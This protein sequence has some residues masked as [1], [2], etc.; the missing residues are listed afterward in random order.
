LTPMV[1]LE[2]LK[3]KPALSNAIELIKKF[4][5]LGMIFVEFKK[6]L[7][8]M[9]D[10]TVLLTHH[11]I[12]FLNDTSFLKKFQTKMVGKPTKEEFADFESKLLKLWKKTELCPLYSPK[13]YKT[14]MN[15]DVSY[16][17]LK[18]IYSSTN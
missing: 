16:K 14:M 7:T 3:Q 6:E 4:E 8:D 9:V 5:S 15:L 10:Q 13:L 1:V 17:I 2:V 18:L 12:G 11:V